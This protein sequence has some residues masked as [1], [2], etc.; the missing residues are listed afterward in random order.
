MYNHVLIDGDIILNKACFSCQRTLYHVVLPSE[1]DNYILEQFSSLRAA[2][3]FAA[4]VEEPVYI[5][6]FKIYEKEY[7]LY[8]RIN[9]LIESILKELNC[10]TYTVYI[11]AGSKVKTFRHLIYPEYKQNRKEQDRP[12]YMSKARAYL[13][14]KYNPV[15]ADN[16]FE[17]D[18]IMGIDLYKDSSAICV[19]I[20]KDMRMIPGQHYNIDTKK[21]FTVSDP[22]ELNLTNTS[23]GK[24][25]LEGI[26]FKWFMAQA[27]LG[28]T[29][30]N[31]KG[32][33]GYGD[34]K[35]F[36]LLEPLQT[37][38][39]MYNK[40]KEIYTAHNRDLELNLDLLW[41]KRLPN[42]SFRDVLYEKTN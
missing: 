31:I 30:D 26:G 37:K 38:L 23:F 36:K 8:S 6:G 22:G 25:K 33:D 28:D 27:L 40:V 19:S 14:K 1:D 17:T 18:D 34:V 41:I 16:E 29:V 4:E 35:T 12:K 5:Q 11:G 39:E 24:K 9:L 42:Q 13:I 21:I 7:L 32:I 10:H 15:I 3:Q 2:R 20:D